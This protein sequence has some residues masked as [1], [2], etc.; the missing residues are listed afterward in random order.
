MRRVRIMEAGARLRDVAREWGVD[1]WDAATPT[2]L[3]NAVEMEWLRTV[4]A[5][6]R[7]ALAQREARRR[8]WEPAA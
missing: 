6:E 5:E 3:R 1:A 2:H 8:A 7:R 4:E